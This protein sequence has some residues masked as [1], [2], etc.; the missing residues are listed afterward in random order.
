MSHDT[1]SI[2]MVKK[3]SSNKAVRIC[4]HSRSKHWHFHMIIIRT[5]T[6]PKIHYGMEREKHLLVKKEASKIIIDINFLKYIP[7]HYQFLRASLTLF[8]TLFPHQFT[9]SFLSHPL[10]PQN[11]VN[12]DCNYLTP[13]SVAASYP[14]LPWKY[15]SVRNSPYL[16]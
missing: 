4:L 6:Q 14:S 11:S 3:S 5:W 1:H 10:H 13:N 7:F 2:F 8:S 15:G 9:N 16:I 12:W